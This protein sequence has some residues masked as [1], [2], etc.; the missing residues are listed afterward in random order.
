M[1]PETAKEVRADKPFMSFILQG[2]GVGGRPRIPGIL[3]DAICEINPA[4]EQV[5]IWHAYEHLDPEKDTGCPID[6]LT[7]WTHLN[8]VEKTPEGNVL[9]SS[10]KLSTVF[11]IDWPKGDVL[12][13][14]GGRR[15]MSHQHD[16]TMT[17]DGNL[18]V[19]DNGSHHPIQGRSRVIEIDMARKEIVWQY[20]GSPAFSMLSAH[21]AGAERLANGNTLICEGESGR[22]FEVTRECEIC[23]EWVSPFVH[24]FKGVQSVMLFRAHRYTG[25]GPELEGKRLDSAAYE[26]LNRRWGLEGS[27][28]TIS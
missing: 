12:W 9:T 7:S 6:F 28:R 18:L 22:V 24:D 25:D 26:D 17:P 21:I 5:N 11:L 27:T 8:A 14:W 10:Q 3:T 23:W 2:I 1:D 16:P 4:G 19:F 20:Y 15:I 13:R